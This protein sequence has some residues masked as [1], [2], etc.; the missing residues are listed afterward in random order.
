MAAVKRIRHKNSAKK[1]ARKQA[2]YDV[3]QLSSGKGCMTKPV[4]IIE[5]DMK[6]FLEQAIQ[7]YKDLAGPKY[8][9]L[10]AAATPFADDKIARPVDDEAE[11]K[12]SR[13]AWLALIF[14]EQYKAWPVVSLNGQRNVIGPFTD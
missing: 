8:H 4:N 11:A 5:Y 14:F 6:S 3:S 13:H 1:E 12:G 7:R 9:T 2:F 10:K